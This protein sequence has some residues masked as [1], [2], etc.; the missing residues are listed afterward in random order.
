MNKGDSNLS[1]EEQERK[2][3][4]E[5]FIVFQ[6]ENI[7]CSMQ[8]VL[9]TGEETEKFRCHYLDAVKGCGE[10]L[11]HK[12]QHQLFKIIKVMVCIA[13]HHTTLSLN[14]SLLLSL[15]N[16]VDWNYMARDF[17]KLLEVDVFSVLKSDLVDFIEAKGV[18]E[19]DS[20]V[21]ELRA[22]V[23]ALKL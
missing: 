21:V 4:L 14:S 17:T 23:N 16:A 20:G 18:G 9:R 7:S 8:K 10:H 5:D 3:K 12:S 13:K 19:D 22:K 15:V 11:E 6:I 2:N 1:S